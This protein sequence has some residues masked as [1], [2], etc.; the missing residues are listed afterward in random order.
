MLIVG[1]VFGGLGI[2]IVDQDRLAI[3]DAPDGELVFVVSGARVGRVALA[4]FDGEAVFDEML[5]GTVEADTEDAGVDEL[6]DPF[7]E[8]EE[9]GVEVERSGDLAADLA[10]HFDV[11]F[12]GGDFSGLESE[13]LECVRRPGLRERGPGLRELRCA[14]GPFCARVGR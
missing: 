13:S 4:V 7:I 9:D 11:V 1:N 10:E 5:F 14:G 6:I 8:L 3:V 2:D 12:L